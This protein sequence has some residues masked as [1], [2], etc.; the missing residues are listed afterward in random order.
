MRSK[1][2]PG[3]AAFHAQ[4]SH[5]TGELL[6]QIGFKNHFT[7]ELDDMLSDPAH[8]IGTVRIHFCGKPGGVSIAAQKGSCASIMV[9]RDRKLTEVLDDAGIADFGKVNIQGEHC[10]VETRSGIGG[11]F[12]TCVAR[13][14]V[15]ELCAIAL[16]H[17]ELVAAAR[18]KVAMI[19]SDLPLQRCPA[20]SAQVLQSAHVGYRSCCIGWWCR[21]PCS[22]VRASFK[23][24][25]TTSRCGR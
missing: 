15:P 10:C 17:V 9:D 22:R 18:K 8:K 23:H 6:D 4:T 21:Q 14:V 13:K 11:S 2:Q 5:K 1:P 12:P 3:I 7:K 20:A 25:Q 16:K 24:Q 19:C